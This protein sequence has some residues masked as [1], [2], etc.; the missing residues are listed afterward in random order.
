MGDEINVGLDASSPLAQEAVRQARLLVA[1]RLE[2]LT[3]DRPVTPGCDY[4]ALL[5]E[6]LNGEWDD[7]AARAHLIAALVLVASV[8]AHGAAALAHVESSFLFQSTALLLEQHPDWT[9]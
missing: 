1:T 3:A 4:L 8:T 9:I 5:A 7:H 2:L 6:S